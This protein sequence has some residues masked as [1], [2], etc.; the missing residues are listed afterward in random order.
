MPRARDPNRDRA[1]EIWREHG[2][3][4]TNRQIAEQLDIDEKK[5]AV[6][7]QRDKWSVVQQSSNNVVQQPKE[8]KSVV[9][10]KKQ[11]SNKQNKEVARGDPPEEEGE[12]TDK[13]RMFVLEYMR[14]F[15]ATRAALAA[16]YSKRAAYSIGWENLR[17]PEIQAEITLLK[18]QMTA[19]LGLSVHRVIAEYLKIAFADTT[20]YVDFGTN[21]EPVIGMDGPVYDEEGDPVTKTVSFVHFKSAYEVDGTLISEVKQG[22]DGVSIKFYDKMRALKELE[23]YLGYMDEETKLRVQKMQL[24]VAAISKEV[25]SEVVFIKDDLH[26]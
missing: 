7:K 24:E 18:E 4:I 1:L 11:K 26:E 2:G 17:K 21:E 25:E 10:Q 3:E 14:D 20:D 22:R 8:K 19:E 5:V 15:N 12:L 23:K 13:Q 6:W 9:Q 16:G